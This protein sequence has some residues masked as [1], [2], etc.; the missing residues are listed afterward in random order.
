MQEIRARLIEM[1]LRTPTVESFRFYPPQKLEFVPG[2]FSQV[3][4]DE[5]GQ[6]NKELNK[7]LSFSASPEREYIEVTKRLS[8]SSFSERLRGLKIGDEVL[9]RGPLGS[10]TF[11]QSYK[12]IAFLIGGIGI[13]PVV[14]IIEYIVDR[15]LDTDAH[16]VYSNRSEEE[17]AFKNELERWKGGNKNI[18]ISYLVTE[19]PPRDPACIF[20]RIDE[21]FLKKYMRD[22][23]SRIIF[24]FGPPKMAE[25]MFNLCLEMGCAKEKIRTE[26]FIGY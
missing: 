25:A 15:K 19:C 13:T 12:K 2:Q 4:F 7:Y 22:M 17:I 23:D 21:G 6:N 9:F 1:I 26:Q 14:S 11:Q 16:L 10:C 5:A 20:G 8:A 3:I 18:K 24:I